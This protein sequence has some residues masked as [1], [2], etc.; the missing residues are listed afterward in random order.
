MNAQDMARIHAAAFTQDRPWSAHEFAGLLALPHIRAF[1]LGPSFALVSVIADEAELITL[2]VDPGHQGQGLGTRLMQKW[3]HDVPACTAFL[4]VAQD[5]DA[6]IRLYQ[7][8]GFEN[9]GTRPRYY[10]RAGAEPVDALVMTARLTKGQV[11]EL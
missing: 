3:M 4:E 7:R 9:S 1:A 8:C 11:T 2:A 5:N 6:A 10:A